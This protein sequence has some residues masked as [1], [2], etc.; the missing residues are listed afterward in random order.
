VATRILHVSDFH[1]GHREA[2]EPLHA[3]PEL[4]ARLEPELLV[5]TGDLSHRGRREQLERAAELLRGVGVPLFAVPGNHDIPYTFPARFT[6]TFDHWTHVF[7]DPEPVYSSASLVVVGLNSVRP[8]RQQGGALDDDQLD[9]V[10]ARLRDGAAG[11]FRVVALHHHLA[12]PPWPAKRKKPVQDRDRVLQAL[13]DAGTEL[14]LAGHVHQAAFAERR[15]FEA[16]GDDARASLVLAT[17]AGLGRPR[18][19]R[20]GEACGVNV[21]ELGADALV[22]T[23]YSWQQNAFAEIGRR[24]FVRGD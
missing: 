21:Y 12:A 2:L 15:E 6:R 14:V 8:W 18:P 20:K 24:T 7:G 1:I 11:A 23:A 19:Y 22:A 3:L 9:P 16:P 4:V 10:A 13:A 5:A 17:V